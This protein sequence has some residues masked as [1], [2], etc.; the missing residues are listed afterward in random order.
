MRIG[1]TA[2]TLAQAAAWRAGSRAAGRALVRTLATGDE[3]ERM[4][5]GMSLVR[6]GAR[7]APVVREGVRAREGLPESLT[8]LADVG[9]P[10]D[11]ALI[12]AFADDPEPGVREAAR[13]ALETLAFRLGNSGTAAP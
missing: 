1:A 6:G 9:G 3:T 7:A 5:A 11:A 2:R 12:R 13:Q 10:E 8:V 4:L